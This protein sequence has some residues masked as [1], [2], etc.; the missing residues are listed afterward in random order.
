MFFN[1]EKTASK[2]LHL[3]FQN[4][5][6]IDFGDKVLFVNWWWWQSLYVGD[7]IV[8]LVT[9]WLCWCLTFLNQTESGMNEYEHLWSEHCCPFVFARTWTKTNTNVKKKYW[10]LVWITKSSNASP[11]PM[12]PWIIASLL[13]VT[14]KIEFFDKICNRQWLFDGIF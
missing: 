11:T 9:E 13:L 10:T 5:G 3:G 8:M 2:M 1:I 6:A 14:K 7:G 4:K 12:S